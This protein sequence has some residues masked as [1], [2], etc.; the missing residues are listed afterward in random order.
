MRLNLTNSFKT[1]LKFTQEE[2]RISFL[3]FKIEHAIV[4]IVIISSYE[5]S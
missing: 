4:L 1:F 3:L 2:Q 5:L